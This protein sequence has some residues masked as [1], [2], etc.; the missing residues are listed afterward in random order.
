MSRNTGSWL[1]VQVCMI[2]ETFTQP[3]GC[4]SAWCEINGERVLQCLRFRA[5]AHF[6][7]PVT[8][9]TQLI[10]NVTLLTATPGPT[11]QGLVTSP[12]ATG[13]AVIEN[14]MNKL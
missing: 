14:F 9:H 7:D 12:Q 1:R 2:R 8:T 13:L 10:R 5:L 4:F 6:R 11:D 3:Q